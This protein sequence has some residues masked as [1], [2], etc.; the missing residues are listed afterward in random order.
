MG[1]RNFL[2]QIENQ[3]FSSLKQIIF[4]L[5][6]LVFIIARIN[7]NVVPIFERSVLVIQDDS[8]GHVIKG[9][10]T[11]TCVLQDCV[12][13]EDLRPQLLNPSSNENLAQ[14]RHRQYSRIFTYYYPLYSILFAGIHS[15]GFSPESTYNILAVS[16]VILTNLA[17]IYFLYSVWGPGPAGIALGILANSL[18]LPQLLPQTILS[19]PHLKILNQCASNSN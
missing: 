12:A 15:I 19:T 17:I 4:L 2:N 3:D 16:G 5:R 1:F 13:L 11:Q 8:Y 14:E 10:Q 18:F 6:F 7:L 9:I